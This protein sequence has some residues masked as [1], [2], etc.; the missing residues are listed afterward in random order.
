MITLDA[1]LAALRAEADPKIAAREYA[2]LKT[3]REI[4]GLRVAR[5]TELAGEWRAEM[6]L[7]E[8]LY[9]AQALWQSDIH[10]ARIAAAKLLTQAR[11][12]PD[13]SGAW[14]LIVSFLPDFDNWAIAD[15]MADAGARRV[16]AD[17]ARLDQIEEWLNS[18]HMWTRRAALMM[19]APLARLNN[20]KPHEAAAR[21]RVLDW[22]AYLVAERDAN[23]QRAIAW[24]IRDLSKHDAAAAAAFLEKHAYVMKAFARKE[25]SQYLPNN[26]IYLNPPEPELPEFDEPEEDLPGIDPRTTG[27]LTEEE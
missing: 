26:E 15:H 16:I 7:S 3:D 2:S 13:D 22:A 27:F 10:E 4:L 1:A 21:A 11:I 19:T 18:E 6:D 25:A 12:R 17:L 24:W 14:D 23:I 20:L 9:L 5:I 8:R